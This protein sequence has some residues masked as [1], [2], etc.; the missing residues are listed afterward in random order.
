MRIKRI[1]CYS[2]LEKKELLN[3][4]LYY[5]KL[6]EYNQETL[7]RFQE[8]IVK[9]TNTI[10]QLAIIS[11]RNN[12]GPN[13]LLELI[14]NDITSDK[15]FEEL[16]N[17][18]KK[19]KENYPEPHKRAEQRFLT[20]V[21]I[22]YNRS[23]KQ[24]MLTNE[25]FAKK[26]LGLSKNSMLTSKRVKEVFEY[27]LLTEQEL[28]NGEP[29]EEFI[30]TEGVMTKAIFSTERIN[31]HKPEINEML[32]EVINIDKTTHFF[33]MCTRKDGSLWTR[34]YEVVDQLMILG[35]AS[36]LLAIPL[37]IPKDSWKDVFPDG[38]PFLIKNNE[39]I[40]TPVV[41]NKPKGI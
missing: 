1:D 17:N 16:K 23:K 12:I 10:L 37:N 9:D 20:E 14:E 4:W 5:Y 15:K 40:A 18:C 34:E 32:D 13:D 30:I 6:T 25:D 38:I 29:L 27:C 35:L 21:V 26:V 28:E 19:L 33:N 31:H 2:Q 3:H 36:E 8:L 22:T 11:Y 7:N 24:K 41:G 39:K